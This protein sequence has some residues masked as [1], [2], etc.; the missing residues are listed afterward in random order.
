MTTIDLKCGEKTVA[1][2][3]GLVGVLIAILASL[4]VSRLKSGYEVGCRRVFFRT[5][6]NLNW[7]VDRTEVVGAIPDS[8]Q[9]IA[10]SGGKYGSDGSQVF[11]ESTSISNADS[12][13]FHVLDWR[14]E[15]SRDVQNIYWKSILL[16]RD[17]DN[18]E[19]LE[20]GYSKDSSHVY[21]ASWVVENAD[22]NTFVVTG[23]ATS[24][25]KDKNHN[26]DMGRL[27]GTCP[28]VGAARIKSGES[29]RNA[30][31]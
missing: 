13:T 14:R 2:I 19:I 4:L 20:R 5:F 29:T 7:Q 30:S 27:K 18:F 25:A 10:G 15:L 21:Y 8:F 22:P 9:T 26:Y 28:G 3:C 16:S 12:D 6:N 24:T 1:K 23:K 11:F 17:P 31:S